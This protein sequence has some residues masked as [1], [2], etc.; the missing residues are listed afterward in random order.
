MTGHGG[1][2]ARQRRGVDA[3]GNRKDGTEGARETRRGSVGVNELNDRAAALGPSRGGGGDSHRVVF[4]RVE[5]GKVREDSGHAHFDGRDARVA[6]G[7]LALHQ[8]RR[9]HL[10]VHWVG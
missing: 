7:S 9:Y 6:R 1:R 2:G 5:D 10:R 8:H 4:E 3:T